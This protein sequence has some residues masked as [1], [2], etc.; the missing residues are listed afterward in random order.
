MTT[1]PVLTDHLGRKLPRAQMPGAQATGGLGAGGFG[2]TAYQA[3]DRGLQELATWQP[4][5]ASADRDWLPD[6]N[7]VVARIRDLCRNNGTVA[8]SVRRYV[9]QAIGPGLRLQSTP[10][11]RALGI[12]REAATELGR[13]IETQWRLFAADPGRYCD[14]GRHCDLGG[15]QRI[16]FRSWIT[17]GEALIVPLWRPGRGGRWATCFQP[18]DPDRLSNPGRGPDSASLRAGIEHDADGAAIAYHLRRAHPGDPAAWDQDAWS[19]ERVP[20]ETAWGRPA[21]LHW[22]APEREGQSRGLPPLA[23]AVKR[24]RMLDRYQDAELAAALLSAIL[25]A[26]IESPLDPELVAEGLAGPG[27]AQYQENRLAFHEQSRITLGGVRIPVLFP[28]EKLNFY[29]PSRPAGAFAPFEES[30]LR[31]FAAATGQSFEDVSQNWSKT[32]Y[33][34]ARASMLSSWRSLE[35]GRALFAHGVCTPMF[36]CWL[37]EA[38]DRGDVVLPPGAP[39]FYDAWTGY[40]A[41]RWIGPGRGW[42]DPVKEVQAAQLRMDTLV[43]TL[44]REAAEQGLDWEEVLHQRR[45]ELDV[46]AELGLAPADAAGVLAVTPPTDLPAEGRPAEDPAAEDTPP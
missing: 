43:T 23:A 16:A 39:G 40:A 5:L 12:T 30:M 27:M 42:V 19:W 22:F 21:C 2:P 4:W 10:D 14:A 31:H 41:C 11:W 1:A 45:R 7:A 25:A 38:I 20:R 24:A 17:T 44:E 26:S 32:N 18:V 34:S 29:A 36:L 8:G 15:L 46:M 13:A 28:G 37:E 33:S 3:A 9:D 35:V 6:R